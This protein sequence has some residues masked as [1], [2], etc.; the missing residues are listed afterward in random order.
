M[1]RTSFMRSTLT[2]AAS[3][4]HQKPP[5]SRKRPFYGPT[6]PRT[7]RGAAELVLAID[8]GALVAALRRLLTNAG[9]RKEV[10]RLGIERISLF[11]W[12]PAAR[13]VLACYGE[14]A[15]GGLLTVAHS[16]G[17]HSK[18]RWLPGTVCTPGSHH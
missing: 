6:K 2:A 14:L 3:T 5:N 9:R 18:L 7:V 16:T 1:S 4:W 12:E 10:V 13:R 11:R 8:A 15:E 17:S